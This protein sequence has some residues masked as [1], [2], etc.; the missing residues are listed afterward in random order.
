MSGL[1]EKQQVRRRTY[2]LSSGSNHGLPAV[3]QRPTSVVSQGHVARRERALERADQSRLL[4]QER[5]PARLPQRK[6]REAAAEPKPRSQAA[7]STLIV[8]L[9]VAVLVV[10]VVSLALFGGSH[11]ARTPAPS[12]KKGLVLPRDNQLSAILAKYSAS[13]V[14]TKPDVA[15]RIPNPT[16]LKTLKTTSYTLKSGDTLSGVAKRFHVTVA[17]LISFNGIGD[18]RR[19]AA[20]M[21]LKIPSMNG[22]LYRVKKGDTL[23][24]IAKREGVKLSHIL[25]ANAIKTPVIV[26]GQELFLPGGHMS[27]FALR[28]ALGT[29]F[30]WP[31]KGVITS[32][33]GMRHDPF[34]GTMEFHNGIDIANSIGTRVNAA[35]DGS[36]ALVGQNRGYGK[37]IILDNGNGFQTLYGHLYKSLVKKGEQVSA[38]Q[39]IALMGDTGYATGPHLHFTIYKN[40]VP[41][42]P[43][44]YLPKR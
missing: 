18:V 38:G 28:K 27:S 3:V 33:F 15:V 30:V 32:P 25:D 8:L 19:L 5:L 23:G 12:P 9:V 20:G 29:L 42:N 43:L 37:F 2:G 22:I 14:N 34:T 4:L 10:V 17:T 6:T 26:P 40:S 7:S 21:K 31:T 36:V 1:I 41:V 13:M 11:H 44:H 35:M 16:I 39:K 24:G